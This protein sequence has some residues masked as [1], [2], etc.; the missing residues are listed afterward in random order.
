[1][2]L[3]FLPGFLFMLSFLL[4]CLS[5]C[6]CYLVYLSVAGFL[7]LYSETVWENMA[8]MCVKTKRL[9]VASVCLGNMANARA[10]R[11]VRDASHE[12][13]LDARVAMLAIQLNMLVRTSCEMSVV[14]PSDLCIVTSPPPPL[15]SLLFAHLVSSL[16]SST[17]LSLLLLCTLP[18]F[19]HSVSIPLSSTFLSSPL[20]SFF[21][22][23]VFCSS[24]LL[25]S[26]LCSFPQPLCFL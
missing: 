3:K 24:Y 23:P 17:L 15:C 2:W 21:S 6:F 12:P 20:L 11:A 4:V 22:S 7:L 25:S 8:R 19:S 10:A 5:F 26:R 13:E 1:M 9:D 18:L 16:L 14:R